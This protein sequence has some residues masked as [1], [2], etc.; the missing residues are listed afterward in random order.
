MRASSPVLFQNDF[1]YVFSDFSCPIKS[2]VGELNRL[3]S[4]HEHNSTSAPYF[5]KDQI[6]IVQT[7][8]PYGWQVSIDNTHLIPPDKVRITIFNLYQSADVSINFTD[9]AIKLTALPVGGDFMVVNP[10][11]DDYEQILELNGAYGESVIQILITPG[12]SFNAIPLTVPSTE[13]EV[14]TEYLKSLKV[15]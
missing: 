1:N 5:L 4:E 2:P 3:L 14:A 6:T 8:L 10:L 12:S 7:H 15:G 9:Q 13:I 11:T